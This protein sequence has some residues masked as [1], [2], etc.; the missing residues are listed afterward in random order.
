MPRNV[1]LLLVE[2]VESL[3]IVGDLVNVRT[4]YARNFLFPR[5][6][7]TQPSE[8][9][10]KELAGKRAE[11]ERM[12]AEQRKQRE[13]LSKKLVGV[14]VHLTRSCNDQ[15]IL[16]G[17]I[18]QQDISA[19][20]M[21]MGHAVKP[22]DVRLGQTIKRIDTYDIHIKLDSDLDSTVKLWVVA[23]RKLDLHKDEPAPAPAADATAEGAA[24]ADGRA[25]AEGKP[26]RAEGKSESRGDARPEGKSAKGDRAEGK[27]EGKSAE[28]KSDKPAKDA[29]DK[30][31]KEKKDKPEGKGKGEGKSD[32]GSS[33]PKSESK[34]GVKVDKP[35][36]GLEKVGRRR[37]D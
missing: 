10:I 3:G 35:D 16:Y 2:N 7:A 1:K 32:A 14:E 31:K 33:A 4:G 21:E 22:R 11:A 29:A 5:A 24:S 34:W 8:E 37:R 20:L 36:F 18:T 9:K 13:E 28:A 19:A 6:L 17:A 27:P 15:G 30:P 23:D 26:A 25:A 12:L